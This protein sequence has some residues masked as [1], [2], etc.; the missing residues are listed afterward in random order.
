[1]HPMNT[2][3]QSPKSLGQNSMHLKITVGPNSTKFVFEF[4]ICSAAELSA[5][6]GGKT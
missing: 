3:L 4:K 5:L 2:D 6:Q 1:M